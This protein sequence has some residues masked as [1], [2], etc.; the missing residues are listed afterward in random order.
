[1]ENCIFCKIIQQEIPGYKIYEDDQVYAFLDITQVTE[2]HTLLVP[3]QHVSDIF[4]YNQEMAAA[5]FS[6]LPRIAKALEKTFPTMKGLNILNNNKELAYQSVFHS[7]IHLIPRYTEKDDFSIHFGNHQ[8][9]YTP[10]L[11]TKI[12][13]SI[14]SQVIND[15]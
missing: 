9:D 5:I 7:H 2:G 1:M 3:K 10:D 12:A 11:M 15:A 8:E 4:S 13:D 14:A 6:C